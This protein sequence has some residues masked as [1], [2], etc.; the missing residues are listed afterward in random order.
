MIRSLWTVDLGTRDLTL[1]VGAL[2]PLLGGVGAVLAALAAVAWTLRD[3]RR[4]STR[5]LLAGALQPWKPHPRGGVANP[6]GGDKRGGLLQVRGEVAVL[7]ERWHDGAQ[8]GD[9]LLEWLA[10]AQRPAQLDA[11]RRD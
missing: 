8:Q 7:T 2:S 6:S 4:L 1:H 11:L 3:L 10:G 9:H 5:N